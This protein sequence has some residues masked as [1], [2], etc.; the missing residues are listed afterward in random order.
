MIDEEIYSILTAATDITVRCGIKIFPL[1]LPQG[2]PIPAITY[3][4]VGKDPVHALDGYTG[5]DYPSWQID[6]WA[7]SYTLARELAEMVIKT[8]TESSLA[9][10]LV[11]ME[12]SYEEEVDI[13]RSSIDMRLWTKSTW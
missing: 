8:M 2:L 7:N 10:S 12:D 11:S 13:Y 1:N 9:A 4:C 6:C 3:Q 5:L